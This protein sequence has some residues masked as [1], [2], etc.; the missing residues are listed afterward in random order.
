VS[1]VTPSFRISVA[2]TKIETSCDKKAKQPSFAQF[3][4]LERY[5]NF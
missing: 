1:H 4:I 2:S 5:L 3:S